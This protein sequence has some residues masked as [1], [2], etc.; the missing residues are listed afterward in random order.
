MMCQTCSDHESLANRNAVAHFS[1]AE[2]YGRF[3]K[4]VV[5]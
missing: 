3:V 2:F 5:S 4:E 1:T